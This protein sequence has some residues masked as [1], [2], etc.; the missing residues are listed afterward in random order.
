MVG[1]CECKHAE[2]AWFDLID[3]AEVSSVQSA[4]TGNLAQMRLQASDQNQ[5]NRDGQALIEQLQEK[6]SDCSAW[7]ML[8]AACC[9]TPSCTCMKR[10]FN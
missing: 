10:M 9:C 7:F 6:V 1:G 8:T 3:T 5:E 4:V 2:Q